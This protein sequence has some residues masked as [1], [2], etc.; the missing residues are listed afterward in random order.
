MLA[1][2][3]GVD[4][5]R[6]HKLFA[7]LEQTMG[8]TRKEFSEMVYTSFENKSSAYSRAEILQVLGISDAELVDE[9]LTE[10]TRN[11]EQFWLYRRALHVV[12][13]M[14]SPGSHVYSKLTPICLPERDRVHDFREAAEAHDIVKMG[15]LM[16][17][18]HESL[19]T[20]YDCSHPCLDRMVEVG[21]SKRFPSR[22][23][24]AG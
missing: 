23:T 14:N 3:Q 7:K 10:N 6:R 22:L 18:S 2:Q 4:D 21:A 13:G 8:C 12:H 5:W 20:K 15:D 16:Q 1:K 24:G 19:S 9:F 17:S 11:M